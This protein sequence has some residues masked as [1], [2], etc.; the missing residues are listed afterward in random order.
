M[1][2]DHLSD[3]LAGLASWFPGSVWDLT[4]K[5]SVPQPFTFI[6]QHVFTPLRCYGRLN[7]QGMF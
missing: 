6:K 1:S 3:S 5:A 4:L 7:I 2:E